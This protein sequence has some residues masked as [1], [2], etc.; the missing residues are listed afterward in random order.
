MVRYAAGT[1][2][3]RAINVFSNVATSQHSASLLLDTYVQN[4]A[5]LALPLSPRLQFYALGLE[6]TC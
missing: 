1:K 4:E 3:H 6:R 2:S 5:H